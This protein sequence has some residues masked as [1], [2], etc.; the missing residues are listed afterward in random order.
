M[1]ASVW[2]L[3]RKKDRLKREIG[4]NLDFLAGSVTTQGPSGGFILT[5]KERGKTKSRYIR[6]G[7]LEEA[8][9]MTTR[10]KRLKQLLKELADL[11]WEI[12]K[13]NNPS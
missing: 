1:G 4:E 7:M 8:R 2:H 3:Q 12:L 10:N 6:V 11:N 9:K 13:L 5:H